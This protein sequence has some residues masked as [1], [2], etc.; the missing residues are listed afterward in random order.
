MRARRSITVPRE[1][2]VIGEPALREQA[3]GVGEKRFREHTERVG[4]EVRLQTTNPIDST[5]AT[6]RLRTKV[7]N[8]PRG[9]AT[10]RIGDGVHTAWSADQVCCRC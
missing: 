10:H 6:V 8:G 7:T 1:K 2:P 9:V 5:F 3:A 4:S